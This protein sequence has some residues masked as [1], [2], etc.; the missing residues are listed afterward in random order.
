MNPEHIREIIDHHEG[1]KK[2]GIISILEDIQAQYSCL[3]EEALKI[4]AEKTGRSLVDIYGVATFYKAFSLKP[5]GKHLI[6]ACLGTAC[7]VR[8]GPR[9]AEEFERQLEIKT[10]ETTKDR[11][12]TL[13]TVN[14]LGAC[15]LGPIVTVDGHYFSNV[16]SPKVKEIIHKA[17][18]GLDRVDIQTDERIFPVEVACPRCNHSLMDRHHYVDGYPSIRVTVSFGQKHGWV[19]LSCLYGSFSVDQEYEAPRD[20]VVNFFCPHCHAELIGASECMTC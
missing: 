6:S 17:R 1:G 2:A 4:V 12:I 18:A 3:P 7:H 10:G 19:R 8:G 15:A 11:E 20:T 5:R 9:I 14:C 16:T 13:E